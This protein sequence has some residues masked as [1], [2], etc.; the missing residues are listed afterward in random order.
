MLEEKDKD[1][2]V[3]FVVNNIPILGLMCNV[4]KQSIYSLSDP[5]ISVTNVN[6][7]LEFCK[8]DAS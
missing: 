5:N 1:F 6:R 3:T 8:L 7:N 2:V 4:I